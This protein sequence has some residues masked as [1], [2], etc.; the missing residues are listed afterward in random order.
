M[1]PGIPPTPGLHV[2]CVPVLKQADAAI[3]GWDMLDSRPHSYPLFDDA[4]GGPVHVLTIVFMGL[5]LLD[6]AFLD[7]LAEACAEEGRWEFMLN[8]APLHVRGG[9]GSPVNPIAVF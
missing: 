8:I 1:V 6:N 3:L 7:P 9:T 2:D 4:P 5:P